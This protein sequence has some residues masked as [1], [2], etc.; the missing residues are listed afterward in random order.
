[1]ATSFI[2]DGKRVDR[3]GVYGKVESGVNNPRL[4]LDSGTVLIIDKDATSFHGNGSGVAGQLK[5]GKDSFYTFTNI[6]S[7]QRWIGGGL[8]Y[9]LIEPL[10]RPFG[11][12]INGA[13]NVMYVRALTT[14]AATNTLAFTNGTITLQA[15]NE[16]VSGNGV[17]SSTKLTRGYSVRLEAGV[18][19]AAK[20]IFK[21]YR[22]SFTGLDSSNQ[23]YNGIS[24]V[25][26]NPLLIA[27]STEVATLEELVEWMQNDSLFVG[28]FNITAGATVTG[29]IVTADVTAFTAHQLFAGGTS[30]YDT[31]RISDILTAIADVDV[32]F[33][34]TAD[35]GANA[36][37]VDNN[38]I[39]TAI[40]DTMKDPA[41][42]FVG[43]G[44]TSGTFTSQSVAA[45]NALNSQYAHVVHGGC[46]VS[47][48]GDLVNPLKEKDALYKAALVVGRLAGLDPQTPGTFKGV[49]IA[50]E[51]HSL[52]D[53]EVSIGLR[54]GVLMTRFV[55]EL[56]FNAIVQA[57][58][59]LQLNTFVVNSD[60]TSH[61]ISLVRIV[62]QLLRGMKVQAVLD[63]LGD[64]V[65]GPNRNTLDRET[66]RVWVKNYL[67]GIEATNTVDNLII[68]SRDVTVE[69]VQD[70]YSVTFGI[71]PNYEVNK[72]FITAR[73]LDDTAGLS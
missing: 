34:L 56:Q 28:N 11:S 20:F 47:N 43:G 7:F 37:S 48:P 49:N 9:D 45:A 46:F 62:R 44:S 71:E 25:D 2:F 1:M 65:N 73:I 5:N 10:F 29:A 26:S 67:K 41:L 31:A 14:T 57:I 35:Q 38:K 52:T 39:L 22:G 63:L 15:K 70:A 60:G 59:T 27:Q 17:L 30:V 13:S 18:N 3:P 24:E 54:E 19:D 4:A 58:N 55:P 66:V 42:L 69:I 32:N 21:M 23:A 61:Q 12:N 68:S 50:G 8:W 53:E 72:I 6:A 40:E 33:I 36:T 16:G 51:S 64:Q